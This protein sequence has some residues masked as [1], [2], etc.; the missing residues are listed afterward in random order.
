MGIT[1]E[2]TGAIRFSEIIDCRILC[3]GV[4]QKYNL[5]IPRV[6]KMFRNLRH[7][8][9]PSLGW[10]G[11]WQIE[12]WHES[13]LKLFARFHPNSTT[14]TSFLGKKD[15]TLGLCQAQLIKWVVY[16]NCSGIIWFYPVILLEVIG[17][18]KKTFVRFNSSYSFLL[19]IYS[20]FTGFYSKCN[21]PTRSHFYHEQGCLV[22]ELTFIRFPRKQRGKVISRSNLLTQ[23][24]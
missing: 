19:A 4:K 9:P 24:E 22:R 11:G 20:L 23:S 8:I 15:R 1:A 21:L 18:A 10:R 17:W 12:G 3:C 13:F 14:P 6:V 16:W 7:W 2:E 5:T